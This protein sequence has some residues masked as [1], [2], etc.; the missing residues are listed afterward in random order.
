MI[1]LDNAA[2]TPVT[3]EVLNEM[4]PYF[5][6]QY[7]NPSSLHQMGRY[8]KAAVTK[9]KRQVAEAI[10]ADPDQIFFT[11]SATESNNWV[12]S[13]YK[14]VICSS[15]EH[16]SVSANPNIT[17]VINNTYSIERHISELRNLGLVD[18]LVS[19]IWVNNETGEIYDISEMIATCRNLIVPFHTDATQA[20]GHIPIDVKKLDCDYLTLAG[21]KFHCCKGIGILYARNPRTLEPMLHG[22]GQQ[23]NLRSSTEAVPLIVGMGKAAELYNYNAAAEHYIKTLRN[24]LKDFITGNIRDV[25]I[26]EA[27][28]HVNNILSVAF[29]GVESERLMLTLNTM[30]ICVSSGSA[31][32]SRSRDIS[33]TIEALNL[34]EDYANGV[35]RFSFSSLNTL[36]EINKTE[37]ALSEAVKIIR[38]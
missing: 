21:H 5:K 17:G 33:A 28:N 20:F 35:I 10:N 38:R 34:P 16:H 12:C 1:Y 7:G 25:I 11:S 14:H 37:T 3:D 9:A 26:N 2:T 4:L 36:E 6:E 13:N 27:E 24:E 18:F 23:D 15:V 29:K 31:C 32:S 22:G 19:H 30:G 8:A